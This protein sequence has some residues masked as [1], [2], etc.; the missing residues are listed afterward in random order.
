MVSLRCTWTEAKLGIT[1]DKKSQ[2][3]SFLLKK[4]RSEMIQSNH[5]LSY[6]QYLLLTRQTSSTFIQL[7]HFNNEVM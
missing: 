2:S 1:Q 5:H 4:V 7:F 6:G 3:D